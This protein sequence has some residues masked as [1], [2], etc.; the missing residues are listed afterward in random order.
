MNPPHKKGRIT[1][2][3]GD[4]LSRSGAFSLFSSSMR[5]S[6]G[7]DIAGTG[8]NTAQPPGD[9]GEGHAPLNYRVIQ[10]EVQPYTFTVHV[11]SAAA[12]TCTVHACT[13]DAACTCTCA[14]CIYAARRMLRNCLSASAWQ[15]A[16]CVLCGPDEM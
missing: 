2:V 9:N 15:L 6:T 12:A 4:V 1:C 16:L 3:F 13:W 8:V 7:P 10:V 11:D 14:C 5:V